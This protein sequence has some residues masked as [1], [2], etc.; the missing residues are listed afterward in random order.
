MKFYKKEEEKESF[1][2][3]KKIKDKFYHPIPL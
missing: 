2:L 1:P 3:N